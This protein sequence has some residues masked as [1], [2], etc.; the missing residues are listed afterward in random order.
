MNITTVNDTIYMTY[1]YYMKYPM[2]A[3]ELK[4]NM[5]LSKNPYLIK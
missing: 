4:L 5:I 3:V 2:T 1:D